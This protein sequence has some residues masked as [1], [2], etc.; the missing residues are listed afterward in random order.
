MAL[1][2]RVPG[3]SAQRRVTWP[4]FF[5]RSEANSGAPVDER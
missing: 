3:A 4:A 2:A 5:A 1:V